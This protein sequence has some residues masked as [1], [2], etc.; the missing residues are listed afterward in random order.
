[1]LHPHWGLAQSGAVGMFAALERIEAWE[2]AV[3]GF[4]AEDKRC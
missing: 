2:V 4:A 3:V 1:M